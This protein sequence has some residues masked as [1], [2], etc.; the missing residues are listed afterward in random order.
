MIKRALF[1]LNV[2]PLFACGQIWSLKKETASVSQRSS[3]VIG[4]M[5]P[6]TNFWIV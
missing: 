2:F 1:S 6:E 3:Q 4:Y 5:V